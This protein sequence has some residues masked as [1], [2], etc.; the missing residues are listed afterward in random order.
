MIWLLL[1]TLALRSLL[2][3]GIMPAFAADVG[4]LI[5]ICTPKGERTIPASGDDGGRATHADATCL[6]AAAGFTTLGAVTGPT[7]WVPVDWLP[8][9]PWLTSPSDPVGF[10][11]DRVHARGPPTPPFPAFHPASIA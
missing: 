1:L 6:F 5:T 11:P 8:F 4:P 7:L 3:P 10:G 9:T 2:A